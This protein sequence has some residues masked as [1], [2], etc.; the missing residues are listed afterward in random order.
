MKETFK[1]STKDGPTFEVTKDLPDNL[2]DPRWNEVVMNPAEDIHEL[3]L[4]AL[5]VKCQAG[6]R[7]RIEQG[8]GAVQ[9]YVDSYKFGARTGGY[10]APSIS[11]ED[12]GAQGFSEEQLA[13]LKAAG[14]NT[15]AAE[16]AA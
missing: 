13:F 1:V 12:A 6:A 3:A 8:E 14:M 7:S 4:Q 10:T 11:A 2:D 5:R 16:E 9:A 15:S